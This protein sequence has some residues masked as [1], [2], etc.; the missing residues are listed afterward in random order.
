MSRRDKG[1]VSTPKA[2]PSG[3]TLLELLVV[4]AIIALGTAGVALAM[5]DSGQ[6]L[7]EREATRLAALLD[8]ARG[9]SRATGVMVTWEAALDAKNQNI[10]R[11]TGLRNKEPL[12]TV[13]LDAQ[14]QVIDPKR[15]I[16]GPDPVIAPQRV[17]LAIGKDTRD[18]ASDGVGAFAVVSTEVR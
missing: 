17:R 15:L 11:W 18:V 9:Q 14:T 2:I 8:A 10:M 3:F 13:W 16:L 1:V 5:R 12:P 7:V 6:T 4:I